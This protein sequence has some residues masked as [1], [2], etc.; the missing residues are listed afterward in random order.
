MEARKRRPHMMMSISKLPLWFQMNGGFVSRL[1]QFEH[2]LL[3]STSEARRAKSATNYSCE[4]RLI[5]PN[6]LIL[7]TA[8]SKATRRRFNIMVWSPPDSDPN[9]GRTIQSQSRPA[10]S[11]RREQFRNP[12]PKTAPIF[13]R[14]HAS[15]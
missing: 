8:A 1:I 2:H 13:V 6:N 15:P 11:D 7:S 5:Q 10:P 4:H 12:K 9:S 3:M 14:A